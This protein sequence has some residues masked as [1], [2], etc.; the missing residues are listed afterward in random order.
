MGRNHPYTCDGCGLVVCTQHA[1]KYRILINTVTHVSFALCPFCSGK[2]KGTLHDPNQ[3]ADFLR[4][5]IEQRK[6]NADCLK[7]DNPL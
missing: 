5:I 4:W 3:M 6:P 7:N 2:F 1:D